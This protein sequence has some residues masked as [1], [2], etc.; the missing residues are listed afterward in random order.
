MNSSSEFAKL[1]GEFG[2]LFLHFLDGNAYLG[3][4]AT[5][6]LY[7]GTGKIFDPQ[8]QN[9]PTSLPNSSSEFAKLGHEFVSLGDQFSGIHGPPST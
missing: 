6:K 2:I 4:G 8:W 9:W 3:W 5:G 1:T 7:F